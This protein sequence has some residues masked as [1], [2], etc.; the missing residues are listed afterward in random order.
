M[1]NEDKLRDY[2]KRVMADLHDTRRRLSEAQSQELEPV[3]IVAMSCRLPGG[4][5]NPDDLWEL[6]SQGRDAVAPFPADRGWDVERL[7]HPDPDHPGTSYAREGGFIDG[8]GDFD[9]AFFGISPR[10]ALTM[11]PQQRLLLETSWEA[12]EAAGIDPASLRG[13]RTGVFVGTNGQ[14]YGTLLMMSPDG[15]EGHSMTGGAAAVASGR[16]SYTLGLEGPAVSIDT[17]CSSSLVALHLAVQALRAGE[18]DLALAGGVTVMATP[19]LY[20][21]SSRQRALSPDG[22]CKSFAAAADGAGFSEGVGW[23]LVERLSDARRHGHQVLAVVRGSAVN[24]DGASNGLTAPNGPAQQRVISQALA[25]ARLSTADVDVVE[26]HGTGTTLGD[27]IE[28]QALLATYGQDRGDAAPLL[29]GSVKSNIGH[30][31]AAA[32]VAGVIKMVLAMRHGVVPATLHVDA[33]SPHID[34]SAGAVE[35]ATEATPWPQTGRT[36]RSA[37]SS[38]GISG[39]N[40]HVILEQPGEPADAP[41]GAPAPGLVD[42]DVTVW[43]VSARSK[44]A[45]AGQAARLAAHVREHGD[46]APAAVGWSLATTRSTFDQRASV[47]GSS[48]EELLS[49]LDALSAGVPAGTVVSGVAA[50]PGAGPVFVFPGQ[51]AQSARMAAGLVGRTPVFDAKLAECQRALAPYLDVDLVSVLTGDDES[52]LERVEVVQ[53]VLWAVGIALAA[54]WEHAGVSPQ[55]VV[56][57]SQGEIGAACVAGILS[58]D[59][60]AKTVALRSRALA[61]LRG[62]GAMASVDLSAD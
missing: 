40:A 3:A 35:L 60:A 50:S 8:A 10:E 57:H 36:R 23:L 38:F 25:S 12:V 45:L 39:T 43:P 13:S 20:I 54:V 46:L 52:W 58:L 53:P 41:A 14:D 17:A 4:V 31:Q 30:A 51:G 33:P 9:S 18:C 7:Y 47:V 37:V 49:G 1:A 16:V 15:D 2:L 32:G 62:T 27:P 29:L 28:A 59:D 56:G 42:A 21:G 61:V 11:D 24:Q 55:A 26:A 44:A 48:L 34:W 22:R 19:G 6:L 5:R